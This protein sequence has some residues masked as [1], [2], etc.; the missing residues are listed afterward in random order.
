MK[1]I[2][3]AISALLLESVISV[4]AMDPDV[5]AQRAHSQID[6]AM[7]QMYDDVRDM[8][9]IDPFSQWEVNEFMFPTCVLAYFQYISPIVNECI[10]YRQRNSTCLDVLAD[11]VP[12]VMHCFIERYILM[13]E[14]H[15]LDSVE[16]EG[17]IS[18]ADNMHF[19]FV[20][21]SK[22][23]DFQK[24]LLQT[25]LMPCSGGYRG[26]YVVR[27]FDYLGAMSSKDREAF[28]CLLTDDYNSES[29]VERYVYAEN[30][31]SMK[32]TFA[33][34]P[35]VVV[36]FVNICGKKARDALFYNSTVFANFSDVL[37]GLR[38]FS[39]D[40][41]SGCDAFFSVMANSNLDNFMDLFNVGSDWLRKFV[42]AESDFSESH[43]S[44]YDEYYRVSYSGYNLCE[45]AYR[46][47]GRYGFNYAM[48]IVLD[49]YTIRNVFKVF[50]YREYRYK[51]IDH[52]GELFDMAYHSG[53]MS[54]EIGYNIC[55]NVF[56]DLSCLAL[57]DPQ[58]INI[59]ACRKY[60]QD[61]M[62][63][64]P[65]VIDWGFTVSF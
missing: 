28:L 24:C 7:S 44:E 9:A 11:V 15:V 33:F 29:S 22:N 34:A 26:A 46:N 36:T 27:Y 40:I 53:M 2:V 21:N 35:G 47:K 6:K 18:M 23:S 42:R 48:S 65:Y 16:R 61:K 50:L 32:N 39:A 14:E 19:F 25:L 13:T 63:K 51:N 10:E 62:P 64:S 17:Y 20:E 45:Y 12:H 1:R 43:S 38:R 4:N 8:I 31:A 57:K 30:L 49:N 60:F 3:M 37:H 41:G 5:V 59:E 52:I 58:S 54:R 56:R 55:N